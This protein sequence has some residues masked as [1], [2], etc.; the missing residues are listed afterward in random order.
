M[1]DYARTSKDKNQKVMIGQGYQLFIILR[2]WKKAYELQTTQRKRLN[3]MVEAYHQKEKKRL[4]EEFLCL[5]QGYQNVEYIDDSQLQSW[6]VQ[7]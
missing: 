4:L 5:K 6:V 7:A 3:A 1:R 2:R